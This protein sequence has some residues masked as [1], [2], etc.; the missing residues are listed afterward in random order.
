MTDK[1]TTKASLVR[2]VAIAGTGSYVPD[3]VL[4]NAELEQRMDTSDEWIR[5]RTGIRERRIA[6]ADQA[7]SDLGAQAALRALE[8]A[9]L[10]PEEVELIICATI[11]PDR[12]F[13]NT[14]AF[15]Q[16]H[17]GATKAFCFG[18]EAACSGSVYAIETARQYVAT[19]LVNNALVV[20]AEKLS[21]IVDWEDRT[22]CVLFGDG[23]GAVVLKPAEEGHV[24]I[25]GSVMGSDGSLADLLMTPGGGSRMPF[26][27]EVLDQRQ[28]FLTMGGLEVFKHAVTQ[29]SAA[30]LEVLEA[31][32]MTRDDVTWVIPHQAN[33]RII[34]AISQRLDVSMD[35]FVVNLE[36]YGN[37]SAAS[38]L[39][40]MD[41]AAR[42]GRLKPGDMIML[43]VFGGGFTWGAQL[44]EWGEI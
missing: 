10:A 44:I 3:Y 29:M 11:S 41:E 36:K 38:T 28:F 32:D 9:G 21:S 31:H 39:I 8:S 40:A 1:P 27:Q 35:K 42:D 5:T 19:G 22:T 20:G 2:P 23:A 25:V 6:S 30:A 18:L 14:G 7:A 16:N 34:T 12:P 17:I 24:G 37:T 43:L 4:T 13:P 33:I 15:I 26:S